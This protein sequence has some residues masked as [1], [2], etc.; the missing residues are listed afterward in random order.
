MVNLTT[1]P[2][3]PPYGF[4]ENVSSKERVKTWFFVTFN[5][6]LRDIFPEKFIEFPQVVQKI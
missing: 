2:P 4:S 3:P 1:P 6:I 5:I